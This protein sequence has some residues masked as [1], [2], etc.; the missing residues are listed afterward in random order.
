LGF[1]IVLKTF[2]GKGIFISIEKRIRFRQVLRVMQKAT[3][4]KG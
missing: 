4:Q 2:R 3:K 1:G